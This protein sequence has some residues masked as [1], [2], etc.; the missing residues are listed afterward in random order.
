MMDF[1]LTV[2]NTWL[3]RLKRRLYEKPVLSIDNEYYVFGWNWPDGCLE[4]V[5]EGTVKE[6]EPI[7]LPRG[8][9][10]KKLIMVRSV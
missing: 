10:P 1:N 6:G 4:I 3:R 7:E 9:S 5:K 2:K 8:I